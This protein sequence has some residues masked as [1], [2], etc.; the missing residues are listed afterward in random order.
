[1]GRTY[2]ELAVEEKLIH[3]AVLKSGV[4]HS[5]ETGARI[6]GS[7]HWVHVFSS[8]LHTLYVV[9]KQRGG[10]VINSRQSH[11]AGYSSGRLVHDCLSSYL[12]MEGEVQHSLCI[13]HLL[14][15]L[16]ALTELGR[17]WSAQLHILLMDYYRASNYGKGVVS[18]EQVVELDQRYT[19]LLALADREEPPPKQGKRGRAKRSKGRNLRDRLEKWREAVLGIAE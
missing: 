12:T 9:H 8:L 10:E 19:D 7:L 16:A 14:R 4:A 1:M 11:L 3:Q 2:D 6:E 18:A 5:D 13:A 17:H 15:E